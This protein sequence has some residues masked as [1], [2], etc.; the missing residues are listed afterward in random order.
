L[1]IKLFGEYNKVSEKKKTDKIGRRVL[2]ELDALLET[3]KKKKKKK[4]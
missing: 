1:F 2:E 3:R 4:N